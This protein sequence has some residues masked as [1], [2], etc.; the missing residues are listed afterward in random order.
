M[1]LGAP[2]VLRCYSCPWVLLLPLG[3]AL[4]LGCYSCH[5]VLAHLLGESMAPALVRRVPY[6]LNQEPYGPRPCF[7]CVRRSRQWGVQPPTSRA[8]SGRVGHA[9]QNL[10]N[11]GD[12]QTAAM[13]APHVQNNSKYM[14]IYTFIFVYIYIC[15][16]VHIRTFGIPSLPF[17]NKNTNMFEMPAMLSKLHSSTKPTNFKILTLFFSGAPLFHHSW[18]QPCYT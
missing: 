8:E 16:A 2:L 18:P 9:R 13:C 12:G 17:T 14:C 15:H 6:Y 7:V 1:S 11:F 3:A 10:S 5:W 4:A